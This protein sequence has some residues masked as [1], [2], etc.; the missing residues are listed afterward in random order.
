[1]PPR[2]Q[3]D[4]SKAKGKQRFRMCTRTLYLTYPQNTATKESVATAIER[5]WG[6]DILCYVIG[7]ELHQDGTP[8]L[9]VYVEFEESQTIEGHALLD[10]LT[11]KHG[12]YQS[13][14]N[15]Y[16]VI[17]YCAKDAKYLEKGI[18][19]AEFLQAREGKKNSVF[20]YAAKQLQ[21]GK[22]VTELNQEMP[23]L[24]L[25]EKR[26]LEEYAA[27]VKIQ[28]RKLTLKDWVEIP[29]VRTMSEADATIATWLNKSVKKERAASALMLW[30]WSEGTM[31][32]KTTFL[33]NL[34]QYLTVYDIPAGDFTQG[35]EDG[36][37]DLAIF[38]EFKGQLKA[39]FLNMWCG[40][41][42]QH[43]NI[44]GAHYVKEQRVPTIICSNYPPH[45]C[46]KTLAEKNPTKFQTIRRRFLV[47]ELTEQCDLFGGVNGRQPDTEANYVPVWPEVVSPELDF[48][49][50]DRP[51]EVVTE[52]VELDINAAR[53][54]IDEAED[55][56]DLVDDSWDSDG[57]SKDAAYNAW[58]RTRRYEHGFS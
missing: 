50:E 1:M 14:R 38:D 56:D 36:R 40:G 28:A 24:V 16:K 47:V 6:D 51:G 45:L 49:E 13:A 31:M 7:E 18:S 34:R 41:A 54:A 25:R 17:R 26:K 12:N 37:Y 4:K 23:G 30:L 42:T 39:D 33:D 21:E 10:G 52:T 2:K 32:G 11:G 58:R 19:V 29:I 46:F 35:W 9:H 22:S 3:P 8:H 15:K 57:K 5:A 55:N 20:A 53:V 43:L 48:N 27:W 44:K